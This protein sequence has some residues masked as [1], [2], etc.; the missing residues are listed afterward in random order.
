MNTIPDI[1]YILDIKGNL[2]KWNRMSE[3]VTGF[4]PEELIGKHVL[5]F[6]P[7]TR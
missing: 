6:F 1:L 5:D 4:S 7:A 2:V 3:K